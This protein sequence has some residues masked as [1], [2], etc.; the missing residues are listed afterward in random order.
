MYESNH[1]AVKREGRHDTL[2]SIYDINPL[3]LL[4][5]ASVARTGSGYAALR[6]QNIRCF[7]HT[8]AWLLVCGTLLTIMTTLWSKQMIAAVCK[9]E[10][11]L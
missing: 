7:Q 8:A 9:F 3:G 10:I 11:L 6:V 2:P 5:E 1:V 4:S